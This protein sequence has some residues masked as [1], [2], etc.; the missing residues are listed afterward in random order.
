ML[1]LTRQLLS[2]VD[3]RTR[4]RLV[5]AFVVSLLLAASEGLALL[6]TVPL[7]RVLIAPGS[8]VSLGAVGGVLVGGADD[9]TVRLGVMVLLLFL[10]R[11]V[12]GLL[13]LRWY[14]SVVLEAESDLGARLLAHYLDAPLSFHVANNSADLQR[15][16]YESTRRVTQD[17]LTGLVAAG[18]DVLVMTAIGATLASTEPV[19]SVTAGLYFFLVGLGYQRLVHGRSVVA[20]QTI[21]SEVATGFRL[22]GQSLSAVR[23]IKLRHNQ[24]FFVDALRRSKARSA[25][26]QR[27]L[28][29]SYQAPRYFLEL[30]L[31]AG[32][33]ALAVAVFNTRSDRDAVAAL[34][35]FLA[36]G[37]R[38]LPS[39]NRVLNGVSAVR[40][41]APF[42]D[43]VIDD[44]SLAGDGRD[45]DGETRITEAPEIR[46]QD[47]TFGYSPNQP[48]LRGITVS[49]PPN[50][51]TAIVGPSGSGKSTLVD[52][53]AGL[54]RPDHGSVLVGG[55][56]LFAEGRGTWQ[57][58]IGFVPQSTVLLDVS[59]REN[60]AFGVPHDEIEDAEVERAITAAQ[61]GPFVRGLPNGANTCVGENGVALSGGQRQR[62]AIARAL[63]LRPRV[64]ILDEATSALD[65]ETEAA[66]SRTLDELRHE[67]TIITVAHRLSTIRN[68]DQILVL[69][70][71]I[72]EASGPFDR[73]QEQSPLFLRLVTLGDLA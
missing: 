5:V 60:V 56:D 57:R 31:V 24:D 11:G 48:V 50:Q 35:F 46:L 21:H 55:V 7:L 27:I 70:E 47:V 22:I 72:I 69:N 30:A 71:G 40:A 62:I 36:A 18:S 8:D 2:V 34:G 32:I 13:Y 15:T 28:L 67:L 43:S 10:G 33:A 1:A 42:L 6:L 52:V 59:I 41:T 54:L 66:I 12:A 37:F 19:L 4:R 73:L 38:L 65:S 26:S 14:L 63:Y 20:A 17:G 16:A 64:L 25:A 49:I 68:S 3:G 51:H 45:G 58:L 44:L 9:P 61:L 23:E 39:L 29:F 53:I